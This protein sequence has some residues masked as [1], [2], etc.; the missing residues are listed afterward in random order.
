M[1]IWT[2]LEEGDGLIMS[3]NPITPDEALARHQGT[4]PD[5]MFEVVNELL[6]ERVVNSDEGVHVRITRDEIVSRFM[7]RFNERCSQSTP[8]GVPCTRK[9]IF[10][11]G[12][13]RFK[14]HYRRV[15]WTMRL[16]GSPETDGYH[17]AFFDFSR[18]K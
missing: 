18:A 10:D 17:G 12:W 2:E 1:G 5:E 16:N 14:A 15:G 13:L 8:P 9:D 11:K 3:V 7:A 4:I 6:A